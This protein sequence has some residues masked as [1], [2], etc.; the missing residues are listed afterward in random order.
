M[1]LQP[2][3]AHRMAVDLFDLILTTN[4]DTLFET[5]ASIEG[6]HFHIVTDELK[7]ERPKR[8]IVKF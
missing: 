6:Q 3:T 2:T 4:V 8:A 5:A 1:G 7:Q